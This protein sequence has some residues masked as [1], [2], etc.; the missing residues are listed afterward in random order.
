MIMKTTPLKRAA[1]KNATERSQL[2]LCIATRESQSHRFGPFLAKLIPRVGSGISGGTSSGG[3]FTS[4]DPSGCPA[5][6]AAVAPRVVP[7]DFLDSARSRRGRDGLHGGRASEQA[8]ESA[9]W[10]V[11]AAGFRWK[12]FIV[13]KEANR[14]K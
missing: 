11:R 10:R 13:E 12:R 4:H 3:T 6:E 2:S 14:R 5:D 7:E 1:K 8:I 9:R